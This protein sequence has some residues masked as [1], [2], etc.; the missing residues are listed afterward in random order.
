MVFYFQ[1]VLLLDAFTAGLQL[2]PFSI[3]FVT[4]GPISGYLSDKYGSRWFATAGVLVVSV[5]LFWFGLFPIQNFYQWLGPMLLAGAGGGMFVAPNVASIMNA[6]PTPRRGVASGMS[7]T[8]I[9]A[10]F[11][12]SLGIAFAVMATSVPTGV[13]QAIFSGNTVAISPIQIQNFVGSIHGL[14][15]LMGFI[16]LL[17][18]VPAF[19]TRRP[20]GKYEITQKTESD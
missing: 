20:E 4:F 9:N 1:G 13:L 16:S 3:A 15:I 5:A 2:I 6:T 10:G 11:L 7:S 19:M 18:A 17:S 8:V 12:L 14:F